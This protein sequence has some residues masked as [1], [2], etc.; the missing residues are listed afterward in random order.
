MRLLRTC[1]INDFKYLSQEFS[2]KSLELIK[3]KGVYPCEYMNKFKRFFDDKLPDRCSFVSSL[4][5]ECISKK[6]YLHVI[7]VWIMF[8]M[9]TMGD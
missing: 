7:D 2:D 4:K 6:D 3:Q 9:K 8:K 1:L 5:V